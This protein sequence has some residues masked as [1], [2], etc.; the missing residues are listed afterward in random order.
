MRT[1]KEML[2]MILETAD[3]DGADP[4][5]NHGRLPGKSQCCP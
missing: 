3:T 4:R 1:E 5:C 2:D